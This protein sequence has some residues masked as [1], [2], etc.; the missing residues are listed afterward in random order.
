MYLV[1][2]G[3]RRLVEERLHRQLRASE[4]VF[5]RHDVASGIRKKII[6][7]RFVQMFM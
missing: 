5:Q 1:I 7:Y 4:F 3:I 2:S 6:P